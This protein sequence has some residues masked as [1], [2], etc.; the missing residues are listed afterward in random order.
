MAFVL[1]LYSIHRL[2]YV[3]EEGEIDEPIFIDSL[4]AYGKDMRNFSTAGG[5]RNIMRFPVNGMDIQSDNNDLRCLPDLKACQED[6][7]DSE[8]KKSGSP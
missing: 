7:G 4:I 5:I 8:L 6:R 2:S 3:Q 1:G